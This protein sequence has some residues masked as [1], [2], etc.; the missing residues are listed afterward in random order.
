MTIAVD[1][2]GTLFTEKNFPY[3]G[4]PIHAN[5]ELV[6]KLKQMGHTII[7]WTCR[8]DEALQIA[9]NACKQ[10][11]LTFDFVNENNPKRIERFKNDCRKIGADIYI[12]D[13]C[14]HPSNLAKLFKH[15]N[16]IKKL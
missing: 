13:R 11:G 3:F 4:Q 9:I 1:F 15:S 16:N 10:F 14:I 2:D 8:V 7:L 5:I 12:D 6:K